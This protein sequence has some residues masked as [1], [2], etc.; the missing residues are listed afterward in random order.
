MKNWNS[1]LVE[2]PHGISKTPPKVIQVEDEETY[3]TRLVAILLLLVR[4]CDE[5]KTC[6]KH[7]KGEEKRTVGKHHEKLDNALDDLKASFGNQQSQSW[8]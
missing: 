6:E 1:F 7:L 8:N 3:K 4:A 5:V 2:A